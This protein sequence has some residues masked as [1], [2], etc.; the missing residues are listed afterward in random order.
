MLLKTLYSP[1]QS[2][3]T[4]GND[5]VRLI[6]VHTPEGGYH[7][8]IN[9]IMNPAS[10]VSYHRLIK[11]DGTEAT[12][13][14]PWDRKAWHAGAVNSLSD[15]I[16]V[17]GFARTFDL[18]DSGVMEAAKLVAG[19]LAVRKLPCQWTTD[20]AKG[21]F[22]RHGDLQTDRSDPTPDLSEWR[23]FV[24][25]VKAEYDSIT[26]PTPWPK[27][28]PQWFWTWARWRLG[29]GEFKECGPAHGPSRPG[30]PVPP[31]GISWAPGGKH[32]WAWRRL[33]ALVDA[34]KS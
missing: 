13:L 30:L 24:S 33:K 11:K 17:E 19:R 14:V 34:Q 15:G 21:G 23:L 2:A 3:R 20:V 1:N 25:M 9:W 22:C 5:A 6:V 28:I 31:P 10:N 32:H 12:Q 29:H 8:T 18:A 27:P 26:S 16:S 4:H 7:S